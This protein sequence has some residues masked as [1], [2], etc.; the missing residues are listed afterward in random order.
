LLGFYKAGRTLRLG[1]QPRS[2]QAEDSFDAGIQR[3]IERILAA[4]SFLFRIEREPAGTAAGVAYRLSDLDL[5]S[6]L[7]FFLWSSIPDD[8]LRDAA[9]RGALNEPAALDQQVRRMLRDSRS[10]ALVDNFASRWLELSKISGVVPDTEL[11]PEFDENLRDAMEQETKLFV[12]SQLHDN[13]SVVELLTADYSFLNERLATHYGIRN[14]YGS[15]FRRV[16]FADPST[17]SGSSRAT[18]R[19]DSTRGGLLGQSSVLTVTSYPNRTSVTMRGRWLLA[20]LLGAPPPPPPP[21]IPALKEAGVEGQ[22]RSLRERMEMHRKNPACASCHQ[23]MD[24]LGFAL[25]NFD[26]LGKW[27]TVS[28]G[29]P[30][31]PAASFPDGTRFEGVAGLRTLLVSHKEDFVRTLS[32][33]LLAYAIGRGLDYHDIPAIRKIS[34]DAAAADYSWSSVI[35][36]IVRSTP[37]S[38]AVARGEK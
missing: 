5:A 6:R 31:D 23:R 20:N 34:R 36:G 4:P 30:I 11:Y 15:H 25:E 32:G 9:V 16:T 22:P 26:A 10:K 24:P 21:D 35:T 3:G 28:D 13:R 38:M 7:S 29:A 14:I 17:S 37:F 2:G 33:K 19:D 8:E 27:R 1:T 12:G 18:S